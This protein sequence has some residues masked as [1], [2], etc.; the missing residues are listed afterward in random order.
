NPVNFAP[1]LDAL[2]NLTL[3]E[4][5]GLQTV[6]LTGISSGASNENDMLEISACSSN[7]Q[8]IPNPLVAYSSPNPTGTLSFTP[9][10][11]TFGSATLSVTVNDGQPSNNL[12]TRSFIVTVKPLQI[13]SIART[14][15]GSIL[16]CFE[17]V[18]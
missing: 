10:A 4:D 15:H 8:L 13:N 18:P 6:N 17:G 7:P 16:L 14:L 9:V 11:H 3:M 1:T 2:I 12:I 5:T